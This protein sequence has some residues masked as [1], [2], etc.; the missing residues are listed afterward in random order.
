MTYEVGK[1]ATAQVAK[2]FFSDGTDSYTI[3]NVQDFENPWTYNNTITIASTSL[4]SPSD[5]TLEEKFSEDG[6]KVA[7]SK[8]F[9]EKKRVVHLYDLNFLVSLVPY[10]WLLH[11]P[12]YH[13]FILLSL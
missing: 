4:E 7:V 1:N 3:F 11:L 13:S 8:R 2:E 12:L 10:F 9:E 6:M 5:L